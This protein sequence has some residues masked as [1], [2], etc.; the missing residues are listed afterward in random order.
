MRLGTGFI[1]ACNGLPPRR[2]DCR[3]EATVGKHVFNDHLLGRVVF[4]EDCCRISQNLPHDASLAGNTQA[5]NTTHKASVK[6]RACVGIMQRFYSAVSPE[7]DLAKREYSRISLETFENL[8]Q[9]RTN[10]L[11]AKLKKPAIGGPLC[12]NRKLTCGRHATD[13]FLAW[14]TDAHSLGSADAG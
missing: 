8:P 14:P 2:R 13:S 6:N 10:G 3:F 12:H 5:S 7:R 4:N 9:G 11:F 1:A